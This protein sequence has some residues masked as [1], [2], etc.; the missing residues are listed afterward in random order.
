M[1]DPPGRLLA[2]G[3]AAEIYDL[4][5]GTVLRRY[6]SPGADTAQEAEVMRYVA[7]RGYPVPEVLSA[8]GPDLV[9]PYIE[10]PT[11]FD[12]VRRRPATL[13][14][15]ARRLAKLQQQLAEIAAPEWLMAPGW[16]PD[17]TGDSV[18]HLD[19][20]PMNV[21]MSPDGPVVIDWTNAAAGPP[22]F[23]ASVTY[24]VIAAFTPD[25]T[26]ERVATKVFAETFRRLRGRR[27]IDAF[28]A[29]ACDHRLADPN[30]TP[31]E[32]EGVAAIRTKARR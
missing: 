31:D 19:L 8:D 32:R 24:V 17:P 14:T 25:D 21:M 13:L 30:L 5:D 15:H 9:M 4:G 29:A 20:H 7:G 26:R 28:L 18:L 10:G 2:S 1:S 16:T 22:G 27:E 11:M 12:E 3:R 23:D 6:R